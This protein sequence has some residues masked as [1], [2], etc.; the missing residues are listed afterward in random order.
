METIVKLTQLDYTYLF[1]GVIAILLG[2]KAIVSLLE[3][4]LEKTGLETK[5]MRK[6]REDHELLKATTEL[7]K[8]TAEN[9]A[10]LQTRHNQDESEFRN[11]LNDYM[12]E[13]RADR[14]A[15]HDEMSQYSNNRIAD[16]QQSIQIQKELMASQKQSDEKLEALTSMFID[17]EIDDMRWEILNFCSALSNGT[18]YNREAFDHVL[19]VY[20]KYE[21]ILEENNME[22]GLV[23]QSVKFIQESYYE[24]LKDR[25]VK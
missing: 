21:K 16:R 4:I 3:W 8:T 1:L 18:K 10:K 15:L 13:S 2:V 12:A 6:K 14:K 24:G 20:D 19:K 9:L 7:A 22:N 11:S 25:T 23:E 5:W 17:K